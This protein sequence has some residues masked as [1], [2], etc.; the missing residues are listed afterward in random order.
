MLDGD[1]ISNN[2]KI[3]SRCASQEVKAI[4]YGY[5]ESEEDILANKIP[6][7]KYIKKYGFINNQKIL[8]C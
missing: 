1:K 8:N 4:K 3:R 2:Y 7:K 5:N 6:F